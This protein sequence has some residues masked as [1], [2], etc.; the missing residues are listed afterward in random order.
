MACR[1]QTHDA[2][3]TCLWCS[4]DALFELDSSLCRHDEQ[5]RG[6]AQASG[7]HRHSRQRRS[8]AESAVDDQ[9]RSSR[10]SNQPRCGR[11]MAR[12]SGA[13]RERSE[14]QWRHNRGRTEPHHR[15]MR[16]QHAVA[17]SC[18]GIVRMT[19]HAVLVMIGMLTMQHA[20]VGMGGQARHRRI[21]WH[22]ARDRRHQHDERHGGQSQP[23][24][25]SL[26]C[27]AF[28]HAYFPGA[29]KAWISLR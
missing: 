21:Y 5:M 7:M 17:A 12:Q 23:C 3:R 22:G 20:I 2:N 16:E 6:E 18:S 9:R 11:R 10:M 24:H 4:S 28:Q 13:W 1:A 26:L 25:E 29:K 19:R 27:G 14:L 8:A 15:H